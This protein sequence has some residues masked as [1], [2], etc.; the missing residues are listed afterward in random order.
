MLDPASGASA[1]FRYP[2]AGDPPGPHHAPS[3][4]STVWCDLL[5]LPFESQSVD[6]I[7]MPHTLEFTADPHG[8]LR[9]VERVLIPEGR[10]VIICG[11]NSLQ[12]VGHAARSA[13]R[14]ANRRALP[15][16]GCATPIRLHRASRTG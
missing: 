15:A 10:L 13:G 16:A 8:L 7:V 9:E 2:W 4:R 11:F 12:P 6:L 5:E 1:P 14:L 3:G